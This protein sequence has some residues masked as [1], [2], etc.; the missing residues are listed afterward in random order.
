MT[1]LVVAVSGT[2]VNGAAPE[3]SKPA[4]EVPKVVMKNL[5]MEGQRAS[6]DAIELPR[7]KF[8][9]ID[10]DVEA[11][12]WGFSRTV[13][14]QYTYV[15][16]GMEPNTFPEQIITHPTVATDPCLRFTATVYRGGA[17]TKENVVGGTIA[18]FGNEV[19]P[20][21]GKVRYWLGT[22]DEPGEYTIVFSMYD[23]KDAPTG[24]DP[25]D[26]V[27]LAEQKIVIR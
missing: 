27:K 7:K 5:R 11:G 21:E 4:N 15:G 9:P 18:I 17:L 13:T 10:A 16:M 3:T 19:K 1:A 22:P 6:K 8:L 23:D 25:K 12:T 24:V 2:V 26:I 14:F 20:W